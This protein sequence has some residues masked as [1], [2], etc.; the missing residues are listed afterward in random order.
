MNIIWNKF[1]RE[2]SVTDMIHSLGWESLQ[3]RRLKIRIILLFKI[4]HDLI[5]IQADQLNS[6]NAR[7]RGHNMRYRQIS[8][9][10]HYYRYS[11]LSHTIEHWN[12]LPLDL[13]KLKDLDT[14]KTALSDFTLDCWLFL[15]L[16]LSV[17][18]CVCVCVCMCEGVCVCV[19]TFWFLIFTLLNHHAPT[20]MVN[21]WP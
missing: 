15:F 12:N 4:I 18:V 8:A 7:T 5:D 13:F 1:S 11:F 2:Y 21:F 16:I 9:R 10:Q 6:S 17:F 3:M 14:F 19:C 20:V